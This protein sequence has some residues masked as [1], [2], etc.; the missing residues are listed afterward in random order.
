MKRLVLTAAAL[1]A[2]TALAAA[3]GMNQDNKAEGA[4]PAPAAQQ[5][6]PAEKVAPHAQATQHQTTGQA[7]KAEDSKAGAQ[8]NTESKGADMKA[9][10]K[11]EMKAKESKDSKESMKKDEKA[12]KSAA[13]EKA[14]TKSKM[15]E[16]NKSK[17]SNDKAAQEK[18]GRDTK[19]SAQ[20]DNKDNN[21]TTGQGAAGA[22]H[23]NLSTEQRTKIRTVFKEKIH[24]KPET[25]V[26]FSINVGTRVPRSVHYHTLP[27][28]VVSIYPEW[29]G[30]YFLM[31]NDE[32]I[33]LDPSSFE[34]VAVLT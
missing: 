29:R 16:D 18:S 12:D 34:I 2:G 1:L 33:V 21:R 23:A 30:Y 9:G 10:A 11:D 19:D 15:S 14:D 7:P 25:H 5:K 22:R 6:A 32:I 8:M 4:A 31:V 28:E 13:S 20:R 3:Q 17:M 27:A 26:N 24:V